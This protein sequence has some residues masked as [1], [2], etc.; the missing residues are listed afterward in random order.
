MSK[1]LLVEDEPSVRMG[2][3]LTLSKAGH[4][5]LEA[6]TASEKKKK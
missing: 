6:A 2:L 5:V 4:Q 1:L 3:R